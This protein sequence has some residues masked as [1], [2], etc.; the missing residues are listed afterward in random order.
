MTLIGVCHEAPAI[1][2]E[3]VPNGSLEDR[4]ICKN[5]SSPIPWRTRISIAT[6][7]CSVLVVLHSSKSHRT[8]HGDLKLANILLDVNFNV[9][10]SHFGLSRTM[11]V[12]DQVTSKYDVNKW[13]KVLSKMS[14]DN[15][16]SS[17]IDI[18][19]AASSKDYTRELDVYSFGII[20]LRLLTGRY[21]W[22]LTE[23]VQV[24]LD[25]GNLDT[26]V[27]CLAGDWPYI[28]AQQLAKIALRCCAVSSQNR[29]DLE[30]RVIGVLRKMKASCQGS[31]L[32]SSRLGSEVLSQAPPY[33]ICPISQ[34]SYFKTLIL[35]RVLIKKI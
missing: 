5:N 28:Q 21:A 20:L 26:L 12:S 33:Y 23:E 4:L 18:T 24:A 6:E 1:I 2:Y 34:A 16:A 14:A 8:V 3:H 29:P 13:S 30:S 19:S 15:E 9:K 25:N 27:D 10:L 31:S 35:Q 22:G 17:S 11:S 7:L 32:G